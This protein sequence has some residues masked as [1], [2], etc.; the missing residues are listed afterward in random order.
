MDRI[1]CAVAE[2][3]QRRRPGKVELHFDASGQL[4]HAAKT[5]NLF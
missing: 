2:F 3:A 5:E 4:V 1:R